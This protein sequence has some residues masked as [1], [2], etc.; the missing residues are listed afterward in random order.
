MKKVLTEKSEGPLT[1]KPKKSEQKSS[2]VSLKRKKEL[3]KYI[4]QSLQK[5]ECYKDD[6]KKYEGTIK[7]QTQKRIDKYEAATMKGDLD[8]RKDHSGSFRLKM[9]S[10]ER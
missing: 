6:Q 5:L 10:K 9:R 2:N 7:R 1:G 4:S 3:N 8:G